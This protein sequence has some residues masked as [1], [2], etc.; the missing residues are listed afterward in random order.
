MLLRSQALVGW[1]GSSFS[2]LLREMR[3]LGGRPRATSHLIYPPGLE[4]PLGK[5][6]FDAAC[7][8]GG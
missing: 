8:L 7:M 5:P 4:G 2:Y 3:A 1:G 6:Q